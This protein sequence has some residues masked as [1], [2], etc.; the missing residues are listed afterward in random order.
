MI[1][2]TRGWIVTAS[3]SLNAL[4]AAAI[5]RPQAGA[6]PADA[7][8]VVTVTTP[9]A[10][11]TAS[12]PLPTPA[13]ASA[14]AA[15]PAFHWREVES[16]DYREYIARLRELGCPEKVIRDIIIAEVDKLYAPRFAALRPPRTEPKKYWERSY[17]WSGTAATKEQQE[18][19]RLLQKEKTELLRVLLGKDYLLQMQAESGQ[20]DWRTRFFGPLSAE[21]LE[22]ANELWEKF[23]DAR[24]ALYRL[25]DG[26]IDQ[27]TQKEVRQLTKRFNEQLGT[28]LTPE[29]VENFNLRTSDL[30]QNLRHELQYFD[31]NEEEFRAVFRYKQG[32]QDLEAERP[33]ARDGVQPTAEDWKKYREQEKQNEE[34]LAA[35]LGT[36]RLKE[37]K[38]QQDYSSRAL[39]EMGVSRDAVLKV[40]DL[41]QTAEAAAS[42]LRNNKSLTDE[43][44]NEAL[45]AI[46]AETE[47]ELA[48]LVGQRQANYYRSSG[49][50]WIRNLAP[51]RQVVNQ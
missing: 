51:T 15:T 19:T 45:A 9:P 13:A 50:Y 12:T 39:F 17:G 23:N 18:Q 41:K 47:K 33:S 46:R 44:R 11:A 27:E 10:A 43:Q 37:F 22:R 48:G 49:G 40:A 32:G 38:L 2:N 28:V 1:V 30:T 5:L 26:H 14:T 25:A 4:L 16:E 24:Q 34:A 7:T 21:K 8:E 6:P 36:E 20:P 3:L 31:V 42:K 35:A 29:E